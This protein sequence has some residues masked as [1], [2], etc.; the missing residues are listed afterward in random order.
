[1]KF[2]RLLS[3]FLI[4]ALPS[5]AQIN[6]SVIDTKTIS[7]NGKLPLFTSKQLLEKY[8]GD[9]IK[10]KLHNPE[11]GFYADE[12]YLN[13]KFSFYSKNGISYL[14]YKNKADLDE[15]DLS[16]SK[17]RFIQFGNVKITNETKLNDLKKYFPKSY[18]DYIKSNKE[19]K[20]QTES[21]FI[22]SPCNS[23]D[24]QIRIILNK[25]LKVKAVAYWT[26]C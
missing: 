24:D 13:V 20:N 9:I 7:L 4:F 21:F 16:K 8:L 19:E 15:I 2:L 26:P 18:A 5:F 1:M 25:N 23:C 11:C 10:K 14:V 12:E 17:D 22:L 6:S 3:I